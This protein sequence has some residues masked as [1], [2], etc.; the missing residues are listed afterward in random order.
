MGS[1]F[2]IL[3]SSR[4]DDCFFSKNCFSTS[5]NSGTF[6]KKKETVLASSS[7]ATLD[8]VSPQ[9]SL[10]SRGPIRSLMW[11]SSSFHLWLLSWGVLLVMHMMRRR[12]I[13][14]MGTL[15]QPGDLCFATNC[16]AL[17]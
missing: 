4:V 10:K 9:L 8:G 6:F 13:R 11:Q 2:K 12:Q 15:P 5:V 14:T 3:A 16:G 17:A 7:A 1:F